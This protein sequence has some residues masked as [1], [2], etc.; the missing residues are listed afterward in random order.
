MPKDVADSQARSVE[1]RPKR[2]PPEVQIVGSPAYDLL[3]SLYIAFSQRN[4]D[5]ELDP[6]WWVTQA[7]EKC[8]PELLATLSLFFGDEEESQWCAGRLCTL[9]WRS[10]A[11]HSISAT[12]DWLAQ[13]PP[14]DVLTVLLDR[15]GLGDDWYDTALELIRAHSGKKGGKNEP[16]KSVQAFARRYPSGERAA[17]IRFLTAPNAEQERLINAL[18]EWHALVFAQEEDRVTAAVTREAAAV[19][20][21]AAELSPAELFASVVKG[22]EFDL[23]AA[24]ERLVLAPSALIAPTVF[25]FHWG[26]T[27]TY[28]YPI[29]DVPRTAS[30]SIAIQRREMVRLFEALA[31]DTRLRILRHLAERQ[32][33]LTELS[34]HLKLTKATTRHHMVRLRS[35]GL[36]TVHIRE[37]LSYYSLRRETLD[38][39]TR[40]LLRYLG[41]TSSQ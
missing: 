17:V 9:L 6:Q 33:Y 26:E 5:F 12:L 27:T 8:S 1:M 24:T 34:E 37:H 7:H 15:D 22:I 39:P 28:C 19:Q 32:M 14:E 41:L 11:P 36:V 20:K 23:P 18:R 38:E 29:P 21:R 16:S 30:D 2:K 25:H 4:A 10:P 35:A 31:D 40:L 13:L 3:L